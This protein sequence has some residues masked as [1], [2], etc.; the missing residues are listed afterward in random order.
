M[1][2]PLIRLV[3]INGKNQLREVSVIT[4]VL[5]GKYKKKTKQIKELQIEYD[6]KM[7]SR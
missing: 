2:L 1:F 4:I 3:Y 5:N 7:R 6:G